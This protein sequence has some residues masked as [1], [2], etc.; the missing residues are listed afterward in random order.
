MSWE[1]GQQLQDGKYTVQEELGSGGFGTT[2]LAIDNNLQKVVIKTLNQIYQKHPDFN[3]FKQDFENEAQKLRK[4]SHPHIVQVYDYFQEGDLPC[5]VLEYIDGCNL[6]E[7]VEKYGAFPE[8]EALIYIQQIAEALIVIHGKGLLHRDI[9]PE[10]IML[11]A[12]KSGV[13]LIDFGSTREFTPNCT[14]I[15]TELVSN[16]YSPIEQYSKQTK[17]SIA[18][19]IYALAATLYF[20]L[21]HEL[22]A[23]APERIQKD[24]LVEPKR[25]NTNISRKVNNAILQGMALKSS[26]RPQSV[27]EWL[28][29]LGIKGTT[30]IL[31]TTT[32]SVIYNP[33]SRKNSRFWFVI[34]FITAFTTVALG[35]F[36][37]D[38]WN[39]YQEAKFVEG[40]EQ[41]NN[42]KKYQE[43][44]EKA[45]DVTTESHKYQRAKKLLDECGSGQLAQAEEFVKRNDF[46]RSIIAAK[47]IP[48]ELSIYKE[49]EKIISASADKLLNQAKDL[50]EKEGKIEEAIYLIK[51]IPEKFRAEKKVTRTIDKWREEWKEN[52]ELFKDAQGAF[53]E[54]R[55]YEIRNKVSQIT[56]T[57]WQ[58]KTKSI[59]K[60]ARDKIAVIER[61]K[62]AKNYLNRAI[63]QA[64]NKKYQRAI[65]FGE[66]VSSRTSVYGKAQKM[67]SQWRKRLGFEGLKNGK[68]F[69]K[70]T[71]DFGKYLLLS[72]Q[73]KNIIGFNFAPRS[74]DQVCFKGVVKANKI[75]NV[76]MAFY[77][78]GS[79]PGLDGYTDM[80]GAPVLKN[81]LIYKSSSSI[82][83]SKWYKLNVNEIDKYLGYDFDVKVL[84]ICEKR[85]H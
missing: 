19:D 82:N 38:K 62:Q 81:K 23:S 47:R 57:Y 53:N 77:P 59:N 46:T 6:A 55:W 39:T 42:S 3:K 73:G 22:P 36:I 60:V 49:A 12:D 44:I 28:I 40:I 25:F 69:Y 8:K 29:S 70:G 76:K 34:G 15:H 17:R 31:T 13:V 43:C 27:E 48:P 74:D 10:N 9:K 68:Y 58:N 67:I 4:L 1:K 72:K 16:N 35:S 45:L 20:L 52:E 37:S 79:K 64:K 21:S 84:Q 24:E 30:T 80:A 51:A 71:K 32:K 26:D 5:I 83:L 11:R 66:K 41:L 85:F 65:Y 14:A 61:E 7:W 50:Y 56:T 78:D 75:T 2:Y 18:A 54:S 63:R 33:D